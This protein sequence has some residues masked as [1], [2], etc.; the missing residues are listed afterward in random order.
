M[1]AGDGAPS[2]L[3]RRD[4]VSDSTFEALALERVAKQLPR[5]S[6]GHAQTVQKRLEMY[7]FPHIGKKNLNAVSPSEI[8][9]FLRLIEG[10]G[11]SETASRVLGIGAMLFA[12]AYHM[13]FARQIRVGICGVY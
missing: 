13:V 11:K 3:K 10:R 2:A 7:V 8:L 9:A 5:W 4:F 1:L 6:A 12:M